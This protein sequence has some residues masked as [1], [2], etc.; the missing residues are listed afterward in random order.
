MT[1]RDVLRPPPP[2]FPFLPR[3][4]ALPFPVPESV[5]DALSPP[6]TVEE[7]RH[8]RARE[9][10][11]GFVTGDL[12]V[13]TLLSFRFCFHAALTLDC[14]ALF[15]LSLFRLCS[16]ALKRRHTRSA[17]VRRTMSLLSTMLTHVALPTKC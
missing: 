11:D 4:P 6:L 15:S 14:L 10:V 17:G 9:A 12:T 16:V 13:F 1:A 8:A 7:V 3:L 2:P 5:V